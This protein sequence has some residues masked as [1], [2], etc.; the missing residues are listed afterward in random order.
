MPKVTITGD[1]RIDRKLGK[2]SGADAKKVLRRA[3]RRAV[4]PLQAAA[5]ADAPVDTGRLQAK[6]KV[7]AMKR[8][9]GR[10]GV[11]VQVDQTDLE[12]PYAAVEE[13]GDRERS[14]DHFFEDAF[15]D[16]AESVRSEAI[17]EIA[18]GVETIVKK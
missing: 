6:I 13:F 18:R 11:V 3:L 16:R 7:R 1:K 4:K 9:K 14:G 10:L 15:E 5:K 2:L 8:K 12:K 17:V